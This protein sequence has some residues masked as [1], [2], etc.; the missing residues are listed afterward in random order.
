[1]S[2]WLT[3]EE[4]YVSVV[5]ACSAYFV[6]KIKIWIVFVL[7]YVCMCVCR[8]RGAEGA[9]TMCF[10]RWDSHENKSSVQANKR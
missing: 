7:E 2:N 3:N 1:M 10:M 6:N 5:L 4:K 9:R 8:E